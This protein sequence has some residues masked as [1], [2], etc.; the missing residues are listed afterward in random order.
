M[1]VEI[2]SDGDD[3]YILKFRAR[4]TGY[5]GF[6]HKAA[7]FAEMVAALEHYNR[8]RTADPRHINADVPE[9]PLCRK[10]KAED[11]R[12]LTVEKVRQAAEN[13]GLI[14]ED[15]IVRDHGKVVQRYVIWCNCCGVGAGVLRLGEA[16][17]EIQGWQHKPAVPAE[18]T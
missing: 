17:F 15:E 16:M 3:R 9:C 5:K 18:T 2:I 6:T 10:E 1:S 11:D 7:S 8:P 4:G 14:L 13:K 12:R